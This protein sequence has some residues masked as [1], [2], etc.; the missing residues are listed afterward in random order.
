MQRTQVQFASIRRA[1]HKHQYLTTS[2][3]LG[4]H[5]VHM[6]SFKQ[7]LIHIK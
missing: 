5:V 3:G 7:T 2:A 1:T 6:G 4:E